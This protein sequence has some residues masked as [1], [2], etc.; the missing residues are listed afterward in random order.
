MQDPS[1]PFVAQDGLEYRDLG[2][3]LLGR[4]VRSYRTIR[5][6]EMR[7]KGEGEQV[8]RAFIDWHDGGISGT[9]QD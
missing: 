2:D 3:Y 8:V 5:I 7:A 6:Q 4:P 1:K 9:S